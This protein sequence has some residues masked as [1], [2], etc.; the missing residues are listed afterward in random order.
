MPIILFTQTQLHNIIIKTIW[1]IW[2]I[3]N[4][5]NK[6]SN[7]L[8]KK[9][10]K[11]TINNKLTNINHSKKKS[12]IWKKLIL[13]KA[14]TEKTDFKLN[15]IRQHSIKWLMI[16]GNSDYRIMLLFKPTDNNIV[17]T[18]LPNKYWIIM[19]SCKI[20]FKKKKNS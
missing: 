4:Y 8:K 1:K 15:T 14:F 10:I 2:I 13:L 6:N 17:K 3:V 19:K 12:K 18:Q 9:L 20:C 16:K 7:S 5:L 11:L